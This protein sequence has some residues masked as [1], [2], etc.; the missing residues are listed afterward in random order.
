LVKNKKI[1]LGYVIFV[2]KITSGKNIGKFNVKQLPQ[3]QGGIIV[4]ENETGRILAMQGGYSFLQ[5]EF[6]RSTQAMRQSGSAFKPFVY[7]MALENGF[8]PNSTI[9][10]S[11]IEIDLGY[12]LEVW[13]PRNY[14]GAIIDKITL[15]RALER[16]VNTATVRIA[17]EVGLD[18]IAAIAE[19]FNIF[20]KK[21]PEYLSFALGAGET[22]LLKLTAAYAMLANGGKRITTS[23]I[24]YI[25]DKHG[26]ILYKADD[27]IADN[28]IGFDS[29]LPPKL[30][31]NREQILDEQ[32][33]YQITSLLEGVMIRGSGAPANFL[34]FP[35]AGKTG[36][37]NESRDVWFIGYTPD[38]TIGIFVGFDEQTKNLG[39]N[40]NGTNTALP[41]FIDFMQEAKTF[42]TPKPF[43][44]PKGIKLRKIDL[45]SGG[46]AIGIS[47][48]SI[49]EAFK[50]DEE[51]NQ[52]DISNIQN[53]RKSISDLIKDID[54]KEDSSNEEKNDDD[55][56]EIKPI[57]GIY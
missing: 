53:K 39:K 8:S 6:N 25:Q 33:I 23:M 9:D 1:A 51:I 54:N 38:I 55:N 43:K 50:E 56:K 7:L 22:T 57:F 35:M 31:D 27:R 2:S 52:Q 3:V 40:A 48:N 29:D 21:M 30:N 36:T 44:I 11:P 42:L 45:E 16:S 37:S 15:R 34:N 17:Q 28:S 32:S 47:S 49:I 19:K 5:S 10:S 41:L 46:P 26:N 14:K 24:D 18:K 20:D 12:G 13:K 4:I